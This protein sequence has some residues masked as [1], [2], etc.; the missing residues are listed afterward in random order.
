MKDDRNIWR[1]SWL[2]CINE[3][4]TL[5][6]QNK[7][8]LDKTN[9]NPHWSFVEFICSYFDDLGIEN[10]YKYPL[11]KGWLTE[12]EFE[13]IN[14]WHELLDKYESPCNNDYDH[15]AILNDSSWLDILRTGLAMKSKLEAIL[16]ENEREI[17]ITEINYIRFIQQ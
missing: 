10:N 7:S 8:W 4:T 6:L 16:D 1:E 15:L 13:I 5:D 17:L 12:Y 2:R 11:E 9:T 3:L 14:N